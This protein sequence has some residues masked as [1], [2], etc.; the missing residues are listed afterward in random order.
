MTNATATV[1]YAPGRSAD[2]FGS[3]SDPAVLLWHG[4]QTDSKAALGPLAEAIAAHRLAVVVPDWN[5][6]AADGGRADLLESAAF[7]RAQAAD[8][9]DLVVVG[10]SMGGLAAAGL[11]I[12]PHVAGLQVRHTVCLAGAFTAVDPISGGRLDD[13]LGGAPTGAFTLLHGL[14]DDVVPITVS[15]AFATRLGDVG[16][17]AE[18]V[19]LAADYGSIAGAAYDAADDRYVPSRDPGTAEVTREVAERIAVAAGR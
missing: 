7:A 10:W 15:I 16:W 1:E 19:E 12:N 8:A 11:T 14:H 17:P 13:G 6:H 5:S 3:P 2:L 9:N 18:V 4:M